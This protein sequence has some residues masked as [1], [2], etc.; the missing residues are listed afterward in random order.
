MEEKNS[1]GRTVRRILSTVVCF[2]LIV[3]VLAWATFVLERKKSYHKLSPFF[4]EEQDYDVLF[5]G[6][7]HMINGVLPMQLWDEYGITS[8][9]LGGHAA[10]LP[11]TV[12]LPNTGSAR[13]LGPAPMGILA[14]LPFLA[15]AALLLIRGK[16]NS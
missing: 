10:T 12:C 1:R 7:S 3:A 16:K 5:L 8:Y 14:G 9:N 15:A 6:N 2:V 11:L 4:R 13:L